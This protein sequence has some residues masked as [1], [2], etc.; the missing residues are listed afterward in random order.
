MRFTVATWN[1]DHWKG[2]GRDREHTAKAWRYARELGVDVLLLQ[3]AVPPPGGFE[4]TVFPTRDAL[5]RWHS[6]GRAA[7]GTAIAV[8]GHDAN[9]IP[10]GPLL[11]DRTARLTQTHDAAFVAVR[12]TAGGEEIALVSLYGVL[13]GPLLDKQTYAVT[14]VHRSLSDLTPLLNARRRPRI[15]G[16]DLNVSTQMQPPHRAAHRVVFDRI[17]AFGLGDC[18]RSTA[19]ARQALGGCPCADRDACSHVQTHRHPKSQ[20]PWQLDYLF[21]SERQLMG[22]LKSCRAVDDGRAWEL[23]DH[24]PVV[25]EF[26]L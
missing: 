3:E 24:C 15:I 25:A 6:G 20:V 11:G 10:V 17:A 4:A 18:T 21:A 9:E 26:D 2:V 23:S 12:V 8:F 7:F 19:N 16:G 5:E 13:E 1:M 14:S 22:K